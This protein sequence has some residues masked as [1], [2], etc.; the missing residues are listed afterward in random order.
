MIKKLT[1]TGLLLTALVI[2][3]ERSGADSL[4]SGYKSY[5]KDLATASIWA[6]MRGTSNSIASKSV[7][8]VND[9]FSASSGSIA[10]VVT[11]NKF[12]ADSDDQQYCA[13]LSSTYNQNPL[14]F[15]PKQFDTVEDFSNWF[16]QLSQG[17]GSDGE[18]LYKKCDEDCSPSYSVVIQKSGNGYTVNA[19]TACNQPRDK[20]D[21]QYVLTSGIL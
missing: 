13:Q 16:S 1:Y 21:D 2:G 9:A 11:P 17:K 12:L 15:G 4:P 18:V 10:L 7:S 20:D 3:A 6:N 14:K 5:K 8:M 19:T